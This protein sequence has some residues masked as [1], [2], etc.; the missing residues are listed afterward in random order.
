LSRNPEGRDVT[1]SKARILDAFL[2]AA[3]RTGDRRAL[4]QLVERWNGKLLMHA[5]RLTGD[6]EMARDAVQ[7]S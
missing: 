4:G 5:W 6:G 1:T 3:A 2:V 7:A